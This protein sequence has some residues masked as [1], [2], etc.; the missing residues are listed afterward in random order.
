MTVTTTSTFAPSTG[1][2]LLFALSMCGIRPTAILQ[3]HMV[4][5]RMAA[6]MMLASWSNRQ[7][8]LW[9]VDLVTVPLIAGQATYTV[10]P[11]TVMMLDAYITVADSATSV[12]DRIIFPIS[13]T[14]YASYPDKAQ[15]GVPTVFWFDRLLA[16]TFTLWLVPDVS[17]TYTLNYYRVTRI[18]DATLSSGQQAAIPYLW[19]DA[20]ST[21]LAARLA[22][23]YA[24]D[25]ATGYAT[26][27]E[28]SWMIA[29]AQN[30]ENV[31]LYISPG[32]GG[33][34]VR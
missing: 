17:A 16:P 23:I 1:E 25:R 12:K 20:F 14:E 9:N 4:N 26:L 8:N 32:I 31:N 11:L 6:N 22:L 34:F 3:E 30:T 21:G 28:N 10:D 7:L 18:A 15:Q 33:Y 5:G 2:V 13:R 24:P 27:A 29:A 19:L